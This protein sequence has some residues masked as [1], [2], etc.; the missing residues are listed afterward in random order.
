M[1][2]S[3]LIKTNQEYAAW[4][5]T[6][7]SRFKQSQIKAAVK[8][9]SELL[10]FY[11][12]LGYDIVEMQAESKWG[13]KLLENLSADLQNALPEIKGFSQTNLLYMK[14]FYLLYRSFINFTPQLGE[15][16]ENRRKSM[17]VMPNN[18]EKITPQLGEQFPKTLFSIPWGHHKLLIDKFKNDSQKALFFVY[19]TIEHGWS[20]AMLLNFVESNLYENRGKAI[21]NF[22]DTLPQQTGDLA[23][24]LLKD[25]YNF[26][27][28]QLTTD[29]HEK[30]M[31]DALIENIT[32]FLIE[33]GSGF[34]YMGREYKLTVGTKEQFMDLLFYNTR[35]HCY[36][37]IEIKITE[38]EPSYLGQLNAYVSF[39]NH[40]LKEETDNPTIGLL[41]CK[42]KDNVFAQYSLEGYNQ[43]LGISEYE[44]INILPK[45]FKT[46]LPSIEDIEDQLSL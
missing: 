40:I 3:K 34:A 6:L 36:V 10:Q 17:H 29:F 35:L 23:K 30:E 45:D 15:Q 2:M 8:V 46:S 4:I 26:D 11:W 22:I 12:S 16:I 38:F 27:F 41:I 5:K 20:R 42:S 21:T 39:T 13:D 19:Q 28:L 14:N 37:V 31:K 9:N 18:E 24:E 32:K 33:L 7:S 1:T 43:P 25:P 44:G